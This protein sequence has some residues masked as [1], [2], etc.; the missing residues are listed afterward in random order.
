[1]YWFVTMMN[2]HWSWPH[3]FKYVCPCL[4]IVILCLV[5][6]IGALHLVREISPVRNIE[7]CH[8][9]LLCMTL[10]T[11]FKRSTCA[12]NIKYKRY[13]TVLNKMRKIALFFSPFISLSPKSP[14]PILQICKQKKTP[15]RDTY[16]YRHY[17]TAKN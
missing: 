3:A 14:L 5:A 9:I 10:W 17:I 13:K 4:G 7:L 16:Y 12:K 15:K 6:D 8:T 1:M 2:S 11:L